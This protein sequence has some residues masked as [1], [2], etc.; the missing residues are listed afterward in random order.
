M[1][2]DAYGRQI[3]TLER[4]SCRVTLVVE[5]ALATV[6]PVSLRIGWLQLSS[7]PEATSRLNVLA[8]L[9]M[10]QRL[11][12]SPRRP[13][14]VDAEHLRN[15]MVAFDGEAVGATRRQIASAIYGSTI[16]KDEWSDPFGRLKAM[17]KRDVLRG[18]RLVSVGWR[19]L[20]S[21]GTF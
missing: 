7:L 15:A 20:L 16:V 18:R 11:W 12:V 9:L 3:V 13:G 4:E 21:A 19:D 8:H 14:R 6:G 10:K 1:H 5:G 17:V 2:F